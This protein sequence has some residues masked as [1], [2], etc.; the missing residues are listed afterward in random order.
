MNDLLVIG[1]EVRTLDPA[2]PFAQAIAIRDG[3]IVAVG[4]DDEVRAACRAGV[5]T[6]DGR[7]I[8]IVPGLT[9]SHIHS[10]IGALE[11]Q[12]ADLA[13]AAT[14]D[15]VRERLAAE[16]RRCGDG[17][18]I[19]GHSLE[20]RVFDGIEASGELFA[21][22]VAATRHCSPSS[23][24]TPPSPRR[25]RSPRPAYG[26]PPA[27]TTPP[28][29]SAARTATRPVSC[30]QNAVQLIVTVM[31]EP[32]DDRRLELIANGLAAMNRFGLTAAHMMD[33]T[34]ATPD[35]CRALERSGR[36][37]LRQVVPFTVQ[38]TMDDE[39]IDEAIAA[40]PRAGGCGAPAGQSCSSTA[41]SN[42]AP[43]GWRRRIP[44][45]KDDELARTRTL[46]RRDPAVRRGRRAVD[47]PC[48]RRSRRALCTRRL[49]SGRSRRARAVPRRTHRDDAGRP[50]AAVRGRGRGR[51]AAGAAPA[52]DDARSG[53]SVEPGARAGTL[54][55][56]VSARPS[57]ADRARC[58]WD[59][60]GRWPTSIPGSGWPGRGFA[61]AGD[62]SA[63]ANGDHQRLTALESL[64]GYTTQAALAV[65]DEP[66][67]AG[68]SGYR[69]DLTGFA[70]D[71]VECDAPT[72]CRSCRCC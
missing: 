64:E 72:T 30:A 14:V 69:G 66:W 29:S 16:R 32:S 52:V 60:I 26:R 44:M 47:H 51:L 4:D 36:L 58:S 28:R 46:R 24:S 21:D 31:P 71:P 11:T 50:A 13:G 39:E 19:T 35:E 3:V 25:G 65:S 6:V 9:D 57:C 8:S 34:L 17:E 40:A 10:F 5:E 1:A 15:D 62:R 70:H 20:Y 18:W 56:S 49:P 59:R 48:D 27:S 45:E 53:R 61:A 41:L 12:G 23:T 22:A 68:F 37:S 67:P 33:G 42:P 43:R 2:R 54:R 38:P 55:T 7:G 63:E